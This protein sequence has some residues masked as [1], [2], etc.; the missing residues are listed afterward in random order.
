[1]TRSLFLSTLYPLP[2]RHQCLAG[3]ESVCGI[4]DLVHVAVFAVIVALIACKGDPEAQSSAATKRSLQLITQHGDSDCGDAAI[5]MT[6]AYYGQQMPLEQVQRALPPDTDKGLSALQLM[7]F[8]KARGLGARG[9]AIETADA[10]R[11]LRTGDI[12]HVDGHHYVVIDHVAEDGIHVLDPAT[13][14]RVVAPVDPKAP[15]RVALVFGDS[16][17]ALGERFHASAADF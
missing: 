16:A 17:A 12:L 8:A 9:I 3:N 10:A 14:P 7:N 15:Y 13:G 1:V 11:L 4:V 2:R 5:A 6:L